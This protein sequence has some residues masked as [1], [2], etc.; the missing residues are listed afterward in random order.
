MVQAE[1]IVCQLCELYYRSRRVALP[2]LQKFDEMPI[3]E[4][5]AELQSS[6]WTGDVYLAVSNGFWEPEE[7]EDYE[8]IF[9]AYSDFYSATVARLTDILGE[10]EL[11][12]AWNEND[13]PEWALGLE[14]VAW[15]TAKVPLY[16]RLEHQDPEVP[17]IVALARIPDER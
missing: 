16:V 5:I 12:S 13:F 1:I 15:P 4:R 11:R 2:H 8:S 10:P 7:R 6:H 9:S 17:I 14:I 3:A